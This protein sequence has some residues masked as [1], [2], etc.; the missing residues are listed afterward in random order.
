VQLLS[1]PG[2]DVMTGYRNLAAALQLG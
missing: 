1:A 2:E